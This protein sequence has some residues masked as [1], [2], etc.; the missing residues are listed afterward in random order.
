MRN[1]V[2]YLAL[3]VLLSC[4]STAFAQEHG[5]TKKPHRLA[6]RQLDQITAGDSDAGSSAQ[7]LGGAIVAAGSEATITKSGAMTLEGSAQ[8]GAQALNLVNASQSRV[9]NGVNVWDGRLDT[10]NGATTLNVNQDNKVFQQGFA[11][12]ASLSE[13]KRTDSNVWTSHTSA[14]TSKSSS[15][16]SFTNDSMVDTK[17]SVSSSGGNSTVGGLSSPSQGI[18]LQGGQGI[19][20]TGKLDIHVDAGSIGVGISGNASATTQS[21]IDVGG[22]FNGTTTDTVSAG[23]NANLNWNLPKLDL[24]FDGGICYVELGSCSAKGSRDSSSSSE[25]NKQETYSQAVLAPVS[26]ND[27]K[28]EYIVVDESKLT[29]KTDYTV[30]LNGNSQA[31]AKALNLVNA[32]GSLITN[33]VNVARTPT[34]GP[35]I[36]LNQTNLIVQQH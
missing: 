18:N 17:Q 12:Y 7:D 24:S 14:E 6:D 22:V 26:I 2:F 10:Q 16:D 34:V 33:A 30:F 29:A 3:V 23:F 25:S 35:V 31:D 9:A 1:R 28:A 13:Y 8:Q 32:A 19:S 4:G 27:A 11:T 36:N 21:A 15:S 20:G 5:K